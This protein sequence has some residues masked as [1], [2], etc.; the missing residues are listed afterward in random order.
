MNKNETKNGQ[1]KNK[2]TVTLPQDHP[3]VR[4]LKGASLSW[5]SCQYDSAA[6]WYDTLCKL[7]GEPGLMGRDKVISILNIKVGKVQPFEGDILEGFKKALCVDLF[8]PGVIGNDT[9]EIRKTFENIK[10]VTEALYL[11]ADQAWDLWCGIPYIASCVF[12]E[13]DLD[14]IPDTVGFGPVFNVFIQGQNACTGIICW[15]LKS[16][17]FVAD[18]E[19]FKE[20]DT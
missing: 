13:L 20:W 11:L 9:S 12:P 19:P 4:A 8:D 6:A 10:T 18:D 1:D 17:G 15:L 5:G 7:E 14:N 16:Y 2:V 3:V